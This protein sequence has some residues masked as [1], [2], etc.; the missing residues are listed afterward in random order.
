M[1]GSEEGLAP[2]GT[3]YVL[4]SP[5]HRGEDLLPGRLKTA[6]FADALAQYHRARGRRVSTEYDGRPFDDLRAPEW[7]ERLADL[8]RELTAHA[9]GV[10]LI[11]GCTQID[12]ARLLTKTLRRTGPIKPTGP[13]VRVLAFGILTGEGHVPIASVE[14]DIERYGADAVRCYMIFMGPHDHD[15]NWSDGQ[16]GGIHRF[17]ERLSRLGSELADSPTTAGL[18]RSR[19]RSPAGADLELLRKAHRAIDHVTETMEGDLRL[20][21]AIATIMELVSG[22]TQLRDQVQPATMRFAIQT[23]ASLLFPFAPE[24]ATDVCHQLTGEHAREMMSWPTADPTFSIPDEREIIV[25][26]NGKV[27]D[28]VRVK[29]DIPPNELTALARRCTH[30][31]EHIQGHEIFR[32]VVVPGK[33]VNFVTAQ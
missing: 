13:H 28:R 24:C 1:N 17:L 10:E 26:V 27:R 16:L 9:E 19:S 2:Q 11:V 14:P 18:P 21:V 31:R 6:S 4:Q 7:P 25:Q 33:L 12:E 30:A 8:R 29:R 15:L 22:A 5:P 20:H 3:H 32:E 23:T